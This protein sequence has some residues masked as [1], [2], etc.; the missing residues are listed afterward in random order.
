MYLKWPFWFEWESKKDLYE[1]RLFIFRTNVFPQQFWQKIVPYSFKLYLMLFAFHPAIWY[2]S[3]CEVWISNITWY[4]FRFFLQLLKTEKKKLFWPIIFL[5]SVLS[6][7]IIDIQ[8]AN[9]GI[10]QITEFNDND[11]NS[12]SKSKNKVISN[13]KINDL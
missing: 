12:N 7:S 13:P 10:Y 4:L 5:F 6:G 8:T 11:T 2:L 9:L 1:Y 3:Q